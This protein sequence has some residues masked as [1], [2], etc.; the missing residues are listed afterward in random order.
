MVK[1]FIG[2]CILKRSPWQ[3]IIAVDV[4][5]MGTSAK[6]E[7]GY[8]KKN[9]ALDIYEVVKQYKFEKVFIAG[10]DISSLVYA[11]SYNQV[12]NIRAANKW[13][14][15]FPQDAIDS[16]S[17]QKLSMPVL[18]LAGEGN[19]M[20]E[21]GLQT[22]SGHYQWHTI[23]ETGHFLIEESPCEVAELMIKFLVDK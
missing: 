20:L 4:R 16:K 14:Q 5:G 8:D 21:A 2:I 15:S 23:P 1:T 18:G 6:L 3:E 10:H 17:Y 22:I 9:M 11:A 19:N 12:S 13:Y 7:I